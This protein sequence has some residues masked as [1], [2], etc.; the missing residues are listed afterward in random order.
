VIAWRG[1]RARDIEARERRD[2]VD[3][4]DERCIFVGCVVESMVRRI[5]L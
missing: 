2:V 3:N 5:R 4:R 1:W